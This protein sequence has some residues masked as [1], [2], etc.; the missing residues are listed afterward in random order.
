MSANPTNS[1]SNSG[2]FNSDENNDTVEN[3]DIIENSDKYININ[4]YNESKMVANIHQECENAIE[5][6]LENF[7]DLLLL[8]QEEKSNMFQGM[9]SPEYLDKMD[10]ITTHYMKAENLINLVE[11]SKLR[12]DFEFLKKWD[13]VNYCQHAVSYDIFL[14]MWEKHLKDNAT[15]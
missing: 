14:K 1:G 5:G 7:V 13:N 11:D 15:N 12:A 3:C 4:N 8:Q 6:L 9:K 10:Q 2:V